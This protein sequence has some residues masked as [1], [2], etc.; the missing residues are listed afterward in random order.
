MQSATFSGVENAGTCLLEAVIAWTVIT[1]QNTSPSN[2]Q[3]R[4]SFIRQEG[5][6]YA[7]ESVI[8]KPVAVRDS[9][10]LG[11]PTSALG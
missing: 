9:A 2:P 11:W 1:C 10:G 8:C 3:T 7:F 6:V 5:T 4:S